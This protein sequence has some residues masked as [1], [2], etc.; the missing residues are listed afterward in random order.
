MVSKLSFE[1]ESKQ[2]HITASIDIAFSND[3]ESANDLLA[4]TD[5]TL[6]HVKEFGRNRIVAYEANNKSDS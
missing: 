1:Y 5:Q 4:H 6:Y 3:A 2:F